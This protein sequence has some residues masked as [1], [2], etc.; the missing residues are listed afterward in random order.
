MNLNG[1]VSRVD[2]IPFQGVY[3]RHRTPV[4]AVEVV[5]HGPVLEAPVNH[6]HNHNRIRPRAGPGDGG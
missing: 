6:N 3:W 1:I 5:R 4:P 2:T